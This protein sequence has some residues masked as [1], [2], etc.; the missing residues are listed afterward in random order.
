MRTAGVNRLTTNAIGQISPC[1]NP[2]Q[3]PAGLAPGIWYLEFGPATARV[4]GIR[5]FS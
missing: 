5:Q 3:K 1:H 2:A 4:F